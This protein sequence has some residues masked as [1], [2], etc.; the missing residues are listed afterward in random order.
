MASDVPK[1]S[2][3][4]PATIAGNEVQAEAH[5]Q[6]EADGKAPA[7]KKAKNSSRKTVLS[8]RPKA[9]A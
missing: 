1:S 5:A 6:L 9:K 2:S 4:E 8:A 7:K 3:K